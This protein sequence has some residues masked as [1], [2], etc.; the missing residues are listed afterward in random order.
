[1]R[2]TEPLWIKI[3]LH[4]IG[5]IPEEPMRL[6]CNNKVVINLSNNPVLHNRTKHIEL[7]RHFIREIEKIDSKELTLPFVKT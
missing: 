6:Y 4:D 1:M 7:D 5:I 3:L 2:V